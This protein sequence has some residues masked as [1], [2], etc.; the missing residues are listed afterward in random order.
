MEP[1]K[2]FSESLLAWYQQHARKL[3]WRGLSDPYAVWISEIMAQQTRVDT[4][5]PYF[6]RWMAR[7]PSLQSLASA[8]EQD[9][10]G[11]WEG[12][13][14]YGR[15]RNLLK[16]AQKVQ[17]G[18]TGALPGT[19]RELE[20][21]P[22][23]GRYTAAAISSIAFGEVEPVLD[24]NVKRV[25]ARVFDIQTPVNTP[26]GEK[27]LWSLAE[28]LIPAERPGD[29]NQA[30]MEL[31]ALICT[32]RSPDCGECPLNQDCQAYA[33]GIQAER[34]VLLEKAKIPTV[35][36]TAAIL[37]RGTKVLIARRPSSGLLGGMWEFP[38]GKV[39]G[40]EL[41]QESLA[42]EIKE[43]L[44]AE[45]HVRE[46]LGEYRHA[47]T[48]FKVHLYA[49][50]ADLNNSEPVA[51][52]ASEL[53]WVTPAELKYFPMGK[54]DRSISNDLEKRNGLS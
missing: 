15:A 38:G 30:V 52:E 51:L 9:V 29:Y 17:A 12:L 26:Q 11:V 24:G 7:F 3:P 8:S 25:L 14:Y 21:L 28:Q 2:H 33:L 42:R 32:P 22:G 10:L 45:I 34:P 53:R 18:S 6:K 36:V 44:G 48:H 13:G 16:A 1:T 27:E 47:Y 46:M 40:E 49:F 35:T 54:I 4:V 41:L 37:Q 43:E 50:F 19:R 20:A 23:I 5:I 31:G 39:E